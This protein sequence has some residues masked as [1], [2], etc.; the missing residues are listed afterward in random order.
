ML[1]YCVEVYV[2][3]GYEDAFIKETEKNH[4]NTIKEPG[5]IR[6]DLS[7]SSDTPGLFFLYEVYRDEE[8]VRA[9]KE[10][11]HYAE[12]REAVAP[13]MA[14]PRLGRK[15]DPI[16]PSDDLFNYPV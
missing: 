2:K 8:S 16:F 12:W 9:H 7:R 4:L 3:E 5:N 1:V 10:T 6:F 14:K 13:W 15:F 11:A